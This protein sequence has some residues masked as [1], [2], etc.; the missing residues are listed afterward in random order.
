MSE[1]RKRR[2]NLI[3]ALLI[4]GMCIIIAGT[5]IFAAKYVKGSGESQVSV[6]EVSTETTM[7]SES[8][9]TE[10]TALS[11]TESS[12]E[13]TSESTSE[14]ASESTSE[15]TTESG[16]ESSTD[17]ATVT[18]T[19]TPATTEGTTSSE[20]TT[21]EEYFFALSSEPEVLTS[22][23]DLKAGTLL[24]AAQIDKNNLS[25]Y[26]TSVKIEEGDAVYERIN[27]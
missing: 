14:S 13:A 16:S 21:G 18:A 6:T 26:F 17:K 22:I 15:S 1:R 4:A 27:G 10:I 20:E 12:T 11:T 7:F 19:P 2:E 25:Q 5:I 8:V 24:S 9:P 23:S 3:T